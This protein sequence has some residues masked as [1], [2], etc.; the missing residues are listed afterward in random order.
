MFR[1]GIIVDRAIAG[2]DELDNFLQEYI[3]RHIAKV[4]HDQSLS[5]PKKIECFPGVSAPV[6]EAAL[7]YFRLRRTLEHH[8]DIPKEDLRVPLMR[9]GVFIA[10]DEVRELP[11]MIKKGQCLFSRVVTEEKMFSAGVRVVL[12]PENASGLIFTMRN[13]MAPEIFRAHLEA[14]KRATLPGTVP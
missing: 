10:D 3:D 7:A 5:N 8:L 2:Q 13:I 11:A 14:A 12:T 4:A 6:R 1:S 9:Y